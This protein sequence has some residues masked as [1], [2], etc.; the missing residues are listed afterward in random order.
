LSL[1]L[2]G[3][4]KLILAFMLLQQAVFGQCQADKTSFLAFGDF[5]MGTPEQYQV[6]Q[7]MVD[8]CKE[9]RCD[10]ATL[11]GDNIYPSGVQS[12][13]DLDWKTK[14]EEPYKELQLDFYPTLGNHDYF[15]NIQAQLDYSKEN[16]HWMFPA[17]Y[18]S[19]VECLA[20]F[21]VIDTEN[22][23]EEQILWLKENLATSR[24]HW[25]IL[26]GHRP[27]FSHGGHGDSERLKKDLLP[28]IK[29]KVDFYLS[30]HDHD[31]EYM[32]K[33]YNPDFVVSGAAGETRPVGKGKSTLFSESSVGFAHLELSSRTALVRFIGKNGR[34]LFLHS[35]LS[36]KKH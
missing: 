33:N 32:K 16:P 20:E 30:G 11:L 19:F 9:N 2:S 1:F 35:K 26:I 3:R 6:A 23:D 12:A 13:Y 7:S 8:F 36:G 28:V 18:Y 34:V 4:S 25:K 17:R 5:G 14:F 21:F 27:I 29:N 15:G 24:S 22:F 31:L 10:F